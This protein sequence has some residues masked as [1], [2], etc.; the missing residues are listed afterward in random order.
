MPMVSE[1]TLLNTM[2]SWI[3]LSDKCVQIIIVMVLLIVR[4]RKGLSR[5]HLGFNP[6]PQC[7]ALHM[8]AS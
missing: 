3:F 8:T 1:I 4:G 2:A 6:P 5:P 7:L